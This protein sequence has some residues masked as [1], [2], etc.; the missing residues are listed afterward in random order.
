MKNLTGIAVVTL[1]LTIFTTGLS[2]CSGRGLYCAVKYPGFLYSDL[3]RD[4]SPDVDPSQIEPLVEGNT[5]FAIDLYHE[6]IQTKDNLIFSPYSLSM[7]LAM[8]IGGA[9][10]PTKTEM[11]NVL[12]FTV[13]E[14]DLHQAFNSLDLG[15]LNLNNVASQ[16]DGEFRLHVAN[17]FWVRE[18]LTVKDEFL[19]MLMVNY[20]AGV[21]TIDISDPQACADK[22][23]GWIED[24]TE[25]RIKDVLDPSTIDPLTLAYL[26]NAIYFFSNWFEEFDEGLTQDEPFFLLDTSQVTSPLMHKTEEIAY[27]EGDGF[28][29]VGIPYVV[30]SVKMVI[31]LPESGGFEEFEE[32]LDADTVSEIL[33]NMHN[34]E[35]FLWMPKFECRTKVELSET[36]SD[37]GMPS[38][39]MPGNDAFPDIFEQPPGDEFNTRI[40]RVI[41]EAFILVD[42]SGTEA[43]AVTVVEFVTDSA[44][45]DFDRIEFKADRPFI[46]MII[47]TNTN[48]PLFM[49]RLLDPTI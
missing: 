7:A 19:D 44:P 26:V 1:I 31:M 24:M 46:Y 29:A 8:A 40:S 20:G 13:P 45:A 16:N 23:N 41:H 25:D 28:Q 11:E 14:P 27:Y 18:E 30:D 4:T 43:A 12:H 47:D 6:L 34:R 38:A 21:G 17:S 37:M 36:L 15:L 10:G 9:A 5:E 2:S 35:V 49:G 32:S 39:F 42:E 48:T 22:I 33:H 3:A